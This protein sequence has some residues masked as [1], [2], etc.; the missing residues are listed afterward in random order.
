MVDT[1]LPKSNVLITVGSSIVLSVCCMWG[2]Q[3]HF[4]R[5]TLGITQREFDRIHRRMDM[6]ESRT[7]VW[8]MPAAPMPPRGD[9]K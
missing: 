5:T 8:E 6:L 2:V 7:T 3:T 9:E 4:Y 1:E